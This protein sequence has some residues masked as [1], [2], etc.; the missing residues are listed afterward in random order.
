M[1][2]K[3]LNGLSNQAVCQNKTL[4]N[5]MT[6]AFDTTNSDCLCCRWAM[7][8]F[9]HKT[10]KQSFK[11]VSLNRNLQLILSITICHLAFQ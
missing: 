3:S 5:D 6:H 2:S 11:D 9:R 1:A 7:Q 8:K 10:A 4:Y